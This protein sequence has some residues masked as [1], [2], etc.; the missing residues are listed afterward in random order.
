MLFEILTVLSS[1][2]ILGSNDAVRNSDK[3]FSV[4]ASLF[5]SLNGP[6]YQIIG[7]I[8]TKSLSV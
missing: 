5:D 3:V 8:N 4:T 6:L 2:I 7:D 1:E